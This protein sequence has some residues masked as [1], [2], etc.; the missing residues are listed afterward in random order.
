[1][2]Y[3]SIS[4]LEFEQLVKKE[5]LHILDV[6][7]QEEY[8]GG[9]MKGATLLSLN[10]IPERVGD[11]LV[12]QDYYIICHSGVRSVKACEYLAEKGFRVINV[13]GGMSAWRGEQEHGL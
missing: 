9:H 6:R 7:E 5:T 4:M 13:L 3:Q 1:M 11:L 2:S 10:T 8:E 12:E